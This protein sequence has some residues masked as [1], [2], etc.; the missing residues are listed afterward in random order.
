M[1]FYTLCR[2]SVSD[3]ENRQLLGPLMDSDTW[4]IV[5]CPESNPG[6][7]RDFPRLS[8]PALVDHPVF[9]TVDTGSFL[10]VKRPGPAFNHPPT[11]SAEVKERVELYL[12]SAC[13]PSWQV[14]GRILPFPLHF[15]Q[16]NGKGPDVSLRESSCLFQWLL[17]IT[18][19]QSGKTKSM[20]CVLFLA[21]QPDVCLNF[22]PAAIFK[23]LPLFL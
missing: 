12:Y 22:T 18:P 21:V 4:L 6:R 16:F 20:W 11:S 1:K 14:T 3:H 10:R 17:K 15:T 19:H 7:G 2:F 23:F 9:C 5:D 8:R 13:M